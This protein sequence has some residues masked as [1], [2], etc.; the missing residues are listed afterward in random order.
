MMKLVAIFFLSAISGAGISSTQAMP[1]ADMG[2]ESGAPNM[3]NI[4]R[5]WDDCGHGRY[6]DQNGRC[7]SNWHPGPNGCPPGY[8]LG[9]DVRV[10]IPNR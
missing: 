7:V 6:R 1:I 8:H 4:M 10:C 2:V 3:P 9:W 5:V